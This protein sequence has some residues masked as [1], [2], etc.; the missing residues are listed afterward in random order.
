MSG[1]DLRVHLDGAD[2]LLH[3]LDRVIAG[4]TRKGPMDRAEQRIREELKKYPAPPTGSKYQRT[5]RLREGWDNGLVEAN[6][7]GTNQYAD[8]ISVDLRNTTPYAGYVQDEQNQAEI[9]KD[10][11]KTAQEIVKDETEPFLDDL[12]H[13]IEEAFG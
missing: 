12:A 10:R 9:H 1:I 2:D 5:Y 6:A 8:L 13:S 4:E 7:L 3:K 11:W